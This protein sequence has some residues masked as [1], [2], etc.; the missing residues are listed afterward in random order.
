MLTL[1]KYSLYF[2]NDLNLF[3]P[4]SMR[5]LTHLKRTMGNRKI[6]RFFTAGHYS[7]AAGEFMVKESAAEEFVVKEKVGVNQVC[8]YLEELEYIGALRVER[9]AKNRA[10]IL[11]VHIPL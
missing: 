5:F 4:I 3:F 11:R 6:N 8:K 9:S 1:M 10:S 2:T 7:S